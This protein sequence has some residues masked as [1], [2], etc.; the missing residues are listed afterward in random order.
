MNVYDSI[1][2]FHGTWRTYQ[3]RV[4]KSAQSYLEDKKIHIV[5]APGAGKPRLALNY[6]A[7]LCFLSDSIPRIVIRQRWL[8]RLQPAFLEDGLSPEELFYL[9][10]SVTQN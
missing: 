4:L 8:E 3:T 6:L 9:M 2:S 10:I 5:A 1:L 7:K